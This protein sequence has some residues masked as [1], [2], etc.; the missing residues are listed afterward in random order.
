LC[1]ASGKADW[2]APAVHE[3]LDIVT[4]SG[5][6]LRHAL[7]HYQNDRVLAQ[8]VHGSPEHTNWVGHIVECLEYRD[9]IIQVLGIGESRCVGNSEPDAIGHA[10]R[11]CGLGCLGECGLIDVKAVDT[12]G[13]PIPIK[14]VKFVD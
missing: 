10:S 14:K 1:H 13:Q 11:G 8:H 2:E 7:V 3:P 6:L 5:E 9:E 12:A 4:R